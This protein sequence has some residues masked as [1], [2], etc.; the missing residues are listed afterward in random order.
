MSHHSDSQPDFDDGEGP[1]FQ[2]RQE[3]MRKLLDT[4]GF[5]G[6][7]GS[8]PEGQLS[9]LDEGAIQFAVG[10]H[11]GK[12]IIDF[13]SPVRWMGM[14]AQQAADLA[15]DLM[16]WARLVGRK[17]GETITMTIGGSAQSQ[18]MEMTKKADKR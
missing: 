18:F 12:V 13:G 6:A 16:K 2:K 1:S 3:L 10:S 7:I 15:S 9:K 8:F 14:T 5:R 4:T 11:D 17:Q